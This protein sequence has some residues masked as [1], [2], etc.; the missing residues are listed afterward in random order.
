MTIQSINSIKKRIKSIQIHSS[1]PLCERK[2]RTNRNHPPNVRFKLSTIS[3]FVL[4]LLRHAI[5]D[6][7]QSVRRN[8][9]RGS[10][11]KQ[12]DVLT[13]VSRFAYYSFLSLLL[14]LFVV[15]EQKGAQPERIS[16]FRE[17]FQ[18]RAETNEGALQVT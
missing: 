15:T 8:V 7:N 6:A 13:L 14:L 4:P 9:E 1:F 18:I 17:I 10:S 16:F 12:Q 5:L 3:S 11:S 2:E